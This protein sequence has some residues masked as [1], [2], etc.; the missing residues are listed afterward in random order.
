MKTILVSFVLGWAVYGQNTLNL[1]QDLVRLNIAPTNLV[2]NDPTQD[3]GPLFFR[4]I[5]AAKNR[6]FD[7]VIVDPGAYY[8]LSQQYAGGPHVQ[9]DSLSNLTIDF[10]G[11]DLIFTLPL[12]AGISFSN[13]TNIVVQNFTVDYDPLPFTQVRVVSV[14]AA[15]QQIQFA[16]DGN[17]QNPTALNATFSAPSGGVD[18]HFFRYGRPIPGVSRLHASNPIGSSQFTVT[19]DPGLTPSAIAALIRPGDI[20]FLCMRGHGPSVV[21]VNCTGCTARNIAIYSGAAVGFEGGFARSSLFER[22]YIIP[23]PGTDRLASNFTGI[24]MSGGLGNQIR[25]NRLI[26]TMDNGIEYSARFVGTVKSQTDS[27]TFVLEGLI[28]SELASG[29]SAPNGSAVSFQRPSDGSIVNSAIIA[30]QVAPAFTGQNPYQVS[31]VFDRDLPSSIVGTLMFGTDPDSRAAGSVVE[32]NASEEETGCCNAFFIPGLGD[33]VFRGN[34]A[35]RAAMSGLV[36]E[37]SMQPGNFNSPPAANFAI[38]NNVI[39]SANWVRTGYPLSQVGSIEVYAT[40]APVLVTASP[41]QNI[42]VTGNFIADSGTAAVWLGNTNGGTVSGNDFLHTNINA[43]L[44]SIVSFFGPSTLPVVV[45][46]SQNV[47]TSNNV[48]DQTSGRVWVT[49]GQYRELAAYAPGSTIRLNGY[50]IGTLSNPSVVLTDADGN[51]NPITVQA[52][53]EHAIDV[54]IPAS[55]ALG[56]AYLTLTAGSFKSF[57][58][59]FLDSQDNITALNGCTYEVS[60]AASTTGANANSLAILVVTQAGCS[61]GVAVKDPF[62]TGTASAVGAAVVS[63]G[64]AA[65]TGAARTTA[66]EIAGQPLT[67]TQAA[68]GALR[69][70]IQA[71]VDPWNYGSGV[72]PGEWVTITGTALAAGPPHTWNLNATQLLP[73]SLGGVTVSFNGK[74]AALLYVSATQI[75]ALVPAAVF[76]GSVQVIVESNGV[77][78]DPFTITATA[79]RPAIYALPTSGATFFVTAALAGTATLVGNSAVDPRVLRAVQPGDVLD[80]YMVGL[81]GTVDS[82]KFVTDQLFAG[83]Y[84]VSATVSA[85][86]GGEPAVVSFA[87]LTAPGLYLVRVAIPQDL[88][89]GTQ[90]IQVSAGPSKTGSSLRLLLSPA[91]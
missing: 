68:S 89:P 10:Q 63:V 60:P 84:P 21:V 38:S 45:Q 19:P 55:A 72:A 86:V 69:P 66:I 36:T 81:G 83:A 53:T 59:L 88:S 24:Q 71:I 13:S 6:S 5:L 27:R 43:A 7:R 37:N 80:L 3:S 49:D 25:L 77:S 41:H 12:A 1:S 20:A 74:P 56:G 26:R 48:V 40:N 61:Y 17:W 90:M 28:T 91:S 11:S 75:N 46:S 50:E 65:N 54:Q 2:P 30:S 4:G 51:V 31:Y 14:N 23:K 64:F 47:A 35:Q 15:Q 67:L 79:T 62:V 39:D 22:I 73:T 44:E 34:Y 16:V 52:S 87:G 29:F 58:T 33:G 57:G 9:C 42:S 18:V 76:P 70:V 82:S 32:R 78:G 8:F 85:T